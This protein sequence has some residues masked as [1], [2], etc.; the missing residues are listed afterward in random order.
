MQGRSEIY[1]EIDMSTSHPTMLQTR[2]ASV[3]KRVPLIDDWVRDKNA[4]SAEFSAEVLERHQLFKPTEDVKELVLAMINGANVEKWMREK[5]GVQGAPPKLARFAKDMQTVRANVHVWFPDGW[6]S[7]VGA[8]SDWK[9]R[10]RAVHFLMTSL[11]DEVLEV[12]RE[13]LPKFG[14]ECNALTG[15]GLLARPTCEV[16]TPMPAVLEALAG[17]VLSRTGVAVKLAGK[18]LD[19]KKASEWPTRVFASSASDSSAGFRLAEF[20]SGDG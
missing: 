16:A 13:A 7:T 10:N 8:G 18:T 11:E 6:S 9:R 5:W 17:E 1:V 4:T 3:G 14:V 12:M 19:G 2:L 15:D 20:C